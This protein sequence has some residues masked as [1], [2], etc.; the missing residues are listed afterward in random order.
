[1]IQELLTEK[2][3]PKRFEHLILPERVKAALGHGKVIQNVLLH[4]SP[5]TGK[6]SAAKVLAAGL[7]FIYINVSDESSV[8][9]IR[10]RITEFCSSV[11]VMDFGDDVDAMKTENGRPIKVIILDEVD[12]AS[13]QFF[14]ALRGTIEK[15]ASGSR[16]VATCNFLNKVPDA[17]QSRF[18][19]ISFDFVNKEE[20]SQVRIE[21][22]ERLTSILDKIG[23]KADKE[24][25]EEMVD[26]NF[27]D[28][29]SALNR[30]QSFQVQGISKLT[31]DKVR[32]LS[33]NFEDVYQL[34]SKPADPHANY[35]FI[36][37]NYS[38]KVEDVMAALGSEFI[39]WMKE[40]HP[41]KSKAIPQIIVAVAQHQAQRHLVIDPIV[42]LLSLCFTVQ[43]ILS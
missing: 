10:T 21:W 19:V 32:E 40:K 12:G 20:E 24:A 11:P 34:V 39:K 28:M 26:R 29:R 3:R 16:F 30:I 6:T 37:G 41:E 25:I 23:L 35:E 27:P 14:K 2:L 31:A 7:P 38:S 8:D 36:A 42:S 22:R 4:G 17:I 18:E 15:Y 5:G 33:W 9:T 1:M 13:D 43:K